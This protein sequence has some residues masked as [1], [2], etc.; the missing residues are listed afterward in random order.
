MSGSRFDRCLQHKSVDFNCA[1]AISYLIT[2]F[3]CPYQD[4]LRN[5]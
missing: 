1:G 5:F 3:V 2:F 4:L